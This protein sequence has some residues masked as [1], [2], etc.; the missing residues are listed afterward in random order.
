MTNQPMIASLLS[1]V[2]AVGT[3]LPAQAL[4]S[5]P[6]LGGG[7]VSGSESIP[8]AGEGFASAQDAEGVA[9]HLLADDDTPSMPDIPTSGTCGEHATWSLDIAKRTLTISG[10]GDVTDNSGWKDGASLINSI[11]IEEGITGIGARIFEGGAFSSVSLP[12][13]LASLGEGVFSGCVALTEIDVPSAITSIP[14]STF[15]GCVAL[16]SVTLP[17]SATSIGG[18]AFSG[19][20]KL[21]ELSFPA[22]CTLI[23]DSAFAASG[24]SN[25][26]LPASV[27]TI[28]NQAFSACSSMKTAMLPSALESLGSRAFMGCTSLTS[29]ST[30]GAISEVKESAFDGCTEL[31][32]VS[33]PSS[34]TKI[35]S[36]AFRRCESAFSGGIV[37][38]SSLGEIGSSAFQGCDELSSIEFEG[39]A[40]IISGSAFTQVTARAI[41]PEGNSTWNESVRKNYGGDLTWYVRR[42]DGSL[43]LATRG[44]DYEVVGLSANVSKETT[45]RL[46]NAGYAYRITLAKPGTVR[47]DYAWSLPCGHNYFA[48]S[49]VDD[50]GD[51][52]AADNVYYSYIQEKCTLSRAVNLAAGTIAS[53]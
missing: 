4:A 2:F 25:L 10:T 35:G 21:S 48:I 47:F 44:S 5:E 27:R 13:T 30:L 42:A 15:S 7:G 11:V 26:D 49:I 32:S 31:A 3:C 12:S 29:V 41:F 37:F 24:L 33:I 28:G 9:P 1:I 6:S 52:V 45:Y 50:R 18:K 46:N 34:V 22:A 14:D 19:C 39:N 36:S 17:A 51:Q 53:R 20:V 23:G 8:G 16:S 40:P 38:S 43:A